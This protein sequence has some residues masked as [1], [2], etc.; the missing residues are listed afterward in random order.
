MPRSVSRK[1]RANGNRSTVALRAE[2]ARWGNRAAERTMRS[3]RKRF[4]GQNAL[5]H[6][7]SVPGTTQ[8]LRQALPPRP[9]GKL[10]WHSRLETPDEAILNSLP[11]DKLD[12]AAI[13]GRNPPFDFVAPGLLRIAVDFG[14][15]TVQ[16]RVRDRGASF[17]GSSRAS[18]RICAASR[19]MRIVYAGQP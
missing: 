18:C 4:P 3:T 2:P 15:Q 12:A 17:G 1:T 14:V 5:W 19:A 9:D 16:K 6:V 7:R 10:R 11:R 8:L 13:D